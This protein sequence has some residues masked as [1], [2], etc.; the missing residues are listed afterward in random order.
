[1]R[2]FFAVWLMGTSSNQKID[3]RLL[4]VLLK[5]PVV[6]GFIREIKRRGKKR[7]GVRIP[8]AVALTLCSTSRDGASNGYIDGPSL[9]I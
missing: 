7:T 8:R 1:M 9:F 2:G 5:I 4:A 3:V 6:Q